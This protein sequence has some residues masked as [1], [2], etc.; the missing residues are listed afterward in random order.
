MTNTLKATF[1]LTAI[2]AALFAAYGTAQA[3]ATL[4]QENPEIGRLASPSADDNLS[5]GAGNWSND[6]RFQ[7]QYDGMPDE[8]AYFLFDG[9]V[10]RRNDA[11]GDW[12]R[13]DM[14]NLGLDTREVRIGAERQGDIGG[15]IEF[16]QIPRVYPWTVNSNLLGI[17]QSNMTIQGAPP[18]VERT[19]T[20]RRDRTSVDFFKSL[21]NLVPGLKFTFDYRH[22]DKTGELNYGLG[23]QPLWLAQPI[24]STTQLLNA[25]FE[26]SKDKL[27]LRGGYYA[28]W[29]DTSESL[30]FG[31]R[32]GT[33][34]PGST[35]NPNPTPLSQ[36]LD[37]Q[38]WEVYLD[39]GY[40]FT[41]TT[42]GTFKLKYGEATMD[43]SLPSWGL[44]GVNAPFVNMP[45]KL[46]GQVNTTLVQ[47]GLSSRPMPK[48]SVVANLRYYDMDDQTPLLGV[49][50]NNATGAVQVHNTPQ[51]IETWSGK[52]EGTYRLPMGFSVI[53]GIDGKKQDRSVPQFADEIYVP[54]RS[55][56]DEWNY[57]I[58]VRRGLSETINGSL[59]YVYSTRDGNSYS[60]ANHPTAFAENQINP[61]HIADRDRDRWRLQLDWTPVSNFTVQGTFE[62]ARDDYSNSASRPWGLT[63]GKASLYSI[64]A[65][66]QINPDWQLVAWYAYDRTEADQIG[67]RW[68]RITEV[69][70][71]TRDASLKDKSDSLGVS[72]NGKINAKW[73]VGA[74]VL[75]TKS[76]SEYKET[77]TPTGLGA[78]ARYPTSGGETAVPLPNLTTELTRFRL[79]ADYAVQK[80]ASLRFD[81]IYE[82]WRT[83]DWVY[84][85]SN[86]TPFTFGTTGATAD[87]TF[88]TQTSPQKSTFVGV[89]YKYM[90]E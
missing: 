55:K 52:L 11:T 17:G 57:G 79:F 46:D 47:V 8:G 34:T 26:Y 44:T 33:G 61:I 51:S 24:D 75:W 1:R 70:E 28:T 56:L 12:F 90:L 72:L 39:G 78:T 7:G 62:D 60:F 80:N 25:G 9:Q 6:R 37:N 43:E 30:V 27:Q 87:G 5:I 58:Q 65:T 19:L 41:P 59:G 40:S 35:Q 48:L 63:D 86:G 54:Y 67:G 73:K 29:W 77:W 85:F 74:D 82:D 32:S 4:A 84:S 89:R 14:R 88:F 2:A 21:N 83:N 71:G 69:F 3:Q 76:R 16:N 66:L 23:S 38:S 45:R 13:L 68:D 42:R 15:S 49:V 18:T 20:T 64:D 81:V 10:H 50:G 22:E 36:P 53:G 31:L